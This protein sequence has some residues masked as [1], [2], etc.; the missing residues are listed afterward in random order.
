MNMFCPLASGSKGNC[1][2]LTTHST[3]ILIDLG[4][5]K[6][7][8]INRLRL[9][10]VSLEEIQGIFISHEHTDHIGGLK[11]TLK[12]YNIPVVCNLETAKKI[13]SFLSF[14]PNFKIIKTHEPFLFYDLLVT[15]FN[16]FHDAVDPIGFT[17]QKGNIKFGFCSD[18]G[19]I[20]SLVEYYLSG[21]HYLYIEAN[22]DPVLLSQSNR[23]L[24]YKQRT[25]GK[26]GHL[27][28]QEC[29]KFIK[30]LAEQNL[31]SIYLGHLS[32]ECN[33]P[34]LAKQ[35]VLKELTSFP[36]LTVHVA[37]QEKN[38]IPMTLQQL[39][40]NLDKCYELIS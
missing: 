9:L 5:S 40:N 20:S 21:S 29:A 7:S 3:K 1:A 38:S 13:L 36:H 17:F 22:Y 8:L 35:T 16:T 19:Q 26:F 37:L 6:T 4:I 14:V 39:P 2:L 10:S 28:N 25:M 18:I 33:T 11:S 23:A 32:Q 12:E 34:D 31:I 30:V 27:S 15:S 24:I